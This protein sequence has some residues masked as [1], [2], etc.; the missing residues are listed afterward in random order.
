MDCFSTSKQRLQEKA[1][2]KRKAKQVQ[3]APAKALYVNN[4]NRQRLH[5][6]FRTLYGKD[7]AE[8]AHEDIMSPDLATISLPS[9]V[10]VSNFFSVA[11]SVDLKHLDL[12]PSHISKLPELTEMPALTHVNL[13]YNH[14]GDV[15]V[16]LLFRALVD[17]GSSIEH[18]AVA[19]NDIGDEGAAIIGASLGSLPRLTSL[20]LCDNFI[21]ERGSIAIAEAIAGAT[22]P[23]EDGEEAVASV[24]LLV[25]SVDLKGNRSR[26]LGARRW[27]EVICHH[28]DLKFLNL[29]QNELGCLTKEIFLDLVCG[30]VASASLS[31]LDLQENFPK[32]GFGSSDMGPP[33]PEVIEEL[34]AELPAGEYDPAEVRKGAGVPNCLYPQ[35]P[36]LYGQKGPSTTTRLC[37]GA[38]PSPV[39]PSGVDLSPEARIE[40]L[41]VEN[42]T[43]K[44]ENRELRKKL[45]E[46]LRKG[47]HSDRGRRH[48]PEEKDR[49]RSKE[50][51]AES[52]DE[53]PVSDTNAVLLTNAQME[54]YNE[55]IPNNI[56]AEKRMALV[57]EKL[58]RFMVNFD[59]KVQILDL[60]SGQAVIKDRNSF[61][62]RYTCVFR[63]S[64]SKLLGTCTKRFY[65][66]A[67][68]G[69]TYCL[70]YETHES[71]VTAMPGT[72]PDGKLGVRD[73]RTEHLMVLYEEK[74]GK[75]T[76]MWIKQDSDK[77]GSDPYAGEDI[78][79]A[80]DAYKQFEA[81]LKELKNGKLGERIFHNYHDIPSIG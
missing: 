72:P 40:L 67:A 69:P 6:C 20:E 61:I 32:G 44:A 41:E 13:N 37:A 9:D 34:L 50:D 59:D 2:K 63:E 77:L 12:S 3:G 22:P 39:T 65:F 68:R 79:A 7:D 56:P 30:A 64:G 71:L 42:E 73:P 21:Q 10:D 48:E 17:A 70:D 47:N 54:A 27:A 81:K 74:G 15:G 29:A 26:E 19:S 4:I 25:L 78:L 28:P 5:C 49:R 75:L 46:T 18:L 51:P 31:V 66:D 62:K 36:G 38:A 16:E 14:L 57:A 58:E 52:R 11:T 76:K 35:A 45:V 23:E 55:P 43:L 1:A 8:L 33:P 24:P 53:G 80:S 60:K